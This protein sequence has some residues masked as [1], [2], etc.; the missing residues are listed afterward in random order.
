MD[1]K[2]KFEMPITKQEGKIIFNND[3]WELSG[4][5]SS[6]PINKPKYETEWLEKPIPE[7]LIDEAYEMLDKWLISKGIDLKDLP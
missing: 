3:A 2:N 1:K 6:F 5:R 4:P 7:Q